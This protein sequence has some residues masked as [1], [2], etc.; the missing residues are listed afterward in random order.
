MD[1][2]THS[3]IL[4]SSAGLNKDKLC[5]SWFPGCTN[6]DFSI[7]LQKSKVGHDF[8]PCRLMCQS[9]HW[10]SFALTNTLQT[11][12]IVMLYC[13]QQM[14]Y[15]WKDEC[16]GEP[17][18]QQKSTCKL[19]VTTNILLRQYFMTVFQHS[20]QPKTS[21]QIVQCRT[22]LFRFCFANESH[23][24]NTTSAARCS[25]CF[26]ACIPAHFHYWNFRV[27]LPDFHLLG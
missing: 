6:Q 12:F 19:Y 18:F 14:I 24:W 20:K 26:I 9:A 7:A 22:W 21:K 8:P 13:E 17:V 23:C 10:F 2:C 27:I 11:S 5:I 1:L 25:G 4:F 3:V 15:Y 16:R